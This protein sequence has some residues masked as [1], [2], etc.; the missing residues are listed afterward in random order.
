[1]LVWGCAF[2]ELHHLVLRSLDPFASVTIKGPASWS[3]VSLQTTKNLLFGL[4]HSFCSGSVGTSGGGRRPSYESGSLCT[5]CGRYGPTDKR[6]LWMAGI[7]AMLLTGIVSG[8]VASWAW[9]S[10]MRCLIVGPTWLLMWH[11][12]VSLQNLISLRPVTDRILY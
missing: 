4:R 12:I 8:Y 1:M 2:P 10:L 7:N 9:I 11:F 3:W 6:T 5:L